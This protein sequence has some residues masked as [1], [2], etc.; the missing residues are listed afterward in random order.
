MPGFNCSPVVILSKGLTKAGRCA[1]CFFDYFR[2][3][4]VE[5]E[6]LSLQQHQD[7]SGFGAKPP[8][9]KTFNRLIPADFDGLGL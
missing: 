7:A 8:F 3:A 1:T 2:P 5:E 6:T 9:L 4:L